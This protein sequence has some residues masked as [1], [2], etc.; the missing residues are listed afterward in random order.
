MEEYFSI[1]DLAGRI[2]TYGDQRSVA[3][4]IN[5]Y[6]ADCFDAL[7]VKIGAFKKI[8]GKRSNEAY[9]ISEDLAIQ[10]IEMVTSQEGLPSKGHIVDSI[11]GLTPFND[12]TMK[13]VCFTVQ[14]IIKAN[15]DDELYEKKKAILRENITRVQK[16]C[17]QNYNGWRRAASDVGKCLFCIF[18]VDVLN[19]ETL[20]VYLEEIRICYKEF[21][22]GT[23]EQLRKEDIKLL[24]FLRIENFLETMVRELEIAVKT[25]YITE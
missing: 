10:I 4:A 23:G 17:N 9:K 15:F 13:N 14:Q 2:S 19:E 3:R 20:S 24:N 21:V 18:G 12:P 6:V 22:C 8:G 11:E 16:L 1:Y 25:T 5:R 7:G